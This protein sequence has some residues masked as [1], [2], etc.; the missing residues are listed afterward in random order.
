MSLPANIS[1]NWRTQYLGTG[2]LRED[3]PPPERLLQA[4]WQH[5]RVLRDQLTLADGRSLRVLHPGFLNREPGPDFRDAIVQFGSD[6]PQRGDVEVDLA[7]SGWR[8]HR[9]DVNPD[10]RAVVLHVVWEGADTAGLPTLALKSRLDA[11]LGELAEWF[12]GDGATRASGRAG[13]CCGPLQELPREQ[14]DAIL[15]Q[16]ALI[17]LQLKAAQLAAR[18][19]QGGW[20]R[21]LWEGLF[22]A[23]G[24]QHNVWPLR[25]LAELAGATD[26]ELSVELWQARLTGWS[27]LLPAELPR[28]QGADAEYLRRIWDAWWRERERFGEVILPR[29]AWRMSG[30]RPAN[31]PLRRLALARALAGKRGPASAVGALVHPRRS[32][33]TVGAFTPRTAPTAQRRFLVVALDFRISAPEKAAAVAR[34]RTAHGPRHERH[35]SLALGARC[36]RA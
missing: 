18:A 10:F 7:T 14:L 29:N 13:N 4:V 21:A 17:R 15:Q 26:E 16:A 5:Q 22:A 19:R 32:G 23:L 31:Q 3:G 36:R 11:P 20:D 9:H 24:Y 35:P 8:A 25:R 28:G 30:L 33:R 34:R 1:A 12:S 27:G 6:T 2:P